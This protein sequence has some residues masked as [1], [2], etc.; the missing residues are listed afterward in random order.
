M[1]SARFRFVRQTQL[2][3]ALHACVRMRR[4]LLPLS[5]LIS[6]PLLAAVTTTVTSVTPAELPYFGQDVTLLGTNLSIFCDVPSCTPLRVEVDG[7]VAPVREKAPDRLVI[8]VKAHEIGFGTIQI[9]R[10]DGVKTVVPNALTFLGAE[11]E[12]TVLVPLVVQEREGAFGSRWATSFVA[13][14]GTDVVAMDPL[15]EGN[16]PAAVLWRNRLNANYDTMHLRIRDINREQDASWGTELPI[17]RETDLR[18]HQLHLLDI[19]TDHRFR[20]SL[21]IYT[22]APFDTTARLATFAIEVHRLDPCCDT[23]SRQ[24]LVD[25]NA[26][27]LRGFGVGTFV[28]TQPG[29]LE[30]NDFLASWP[31]VA[32]ARLVRITIKAV[33]DTRPPLFW[34]F[35][36]ITHNTTQHVTL[37]TPSER[38]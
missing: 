31:E 14:N 3:N 16:L 26:P 10:E 38:K 27:A 34:A 5:L 17:V 37:V 28:R 7:V 20:I 13:W 24:Q 22:V 21:R 15:N 18:A 29:Y 9:F 8:S 36:S 23:G 35:A 33:N 4:I 32:D 11:N 12:E 1:R 19:P 30:L 25:I 6:L 2:A